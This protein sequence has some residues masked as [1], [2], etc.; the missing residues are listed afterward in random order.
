MYGYNN[1][2]FSLNFQFKDKDAQQFFDSL[3]IKESRF[4][5]SWNNIRQELTTKDINSQDISHWYDYHQRCV[6]KHIEMLFKDFQKQNTSKAI[7]F[8]TRYTNLS[9]P[10]TSR[11]ILELLGPSEQIFDHKL[12]KEVRAL[13]FNAMI[14]F[15]KCLDVILSKGD[16]PGYLIADMVL[17]L[18]KEFPDIDFG[19]KDFHYVEVYIGNQNNSGSW[20]PYQPQNSWPSVPSRRNWVS[21]SPNSQI[22]TYCFDRDQFI[23]S[24]EPQ[25]SGQRLYLI[26]KGGGES[27]SFPMIDIKNTINRTHYENNRPTHQMPE[28]MS[29]G[30]MSIRDVQE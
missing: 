26:K 8:T 5:L 10:P 3:K 18:P 14:C 2:C 13:N 22:E 1:F 24:I 28:F 16:H 12:S 30:I 9:E 21:R 23:Y 29:D 6:Q 15:A 19:E 11:A 27:Y 7:E 25:E 4:A 17:D 20:S